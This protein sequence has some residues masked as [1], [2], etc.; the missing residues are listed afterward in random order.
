M[1]PDRHLLS[2]IARHTEV[3][4]IKDPA[5]FRHDLCIYPT[6]LRDLKR[7]GVA[8]VTQTAFG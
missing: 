8:K 3:F 7:F 5:R 6:L 4:G 2:R 1:I